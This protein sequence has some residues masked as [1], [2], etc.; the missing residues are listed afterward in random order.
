M[1]TCTKQIKLP[2]V[3]VWCSFETLNLW[4]LKLTKADWTDWKE[5]E[6]LFFL[7]FIL[8]PIFCSFALHSL[9][10]K[11]GSS[12]QV[13]VEWCFF[14]GWLMKAP[15]HK[16]Q[17]CSSSSDKRCWL[18][19]WSALWLLAHL[20]FLLFF[21]PWGFVCLC[22]CVVSVLMWWAVFFGAVGSTASCSQPRLS[23]SSMWL[24]LLRLSSLWYP[25]KDRSRIWCV[26][27][28]AIA[29]S[30]VHLSNTIFPLHQ[31]CS[32]HQPL[33]ERF[34]NSGLLLHTTST[35]DKMAVPP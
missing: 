18:S 12:T 11:R 19:F 14:W 22:M 26:C 8:L 20:L 23:I 16:N 31:R 13:A 33:P 34:A 29:F 6:L 5:H 32:S 25:H 9:W 4:T 7:P 28:L 2:H 35:L 24:S 30:A 1:E 3:D 10:R 27:P 21:S 15:A 17:K